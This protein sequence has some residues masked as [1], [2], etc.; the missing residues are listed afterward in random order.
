MTVEPESHGFI[1]QFAR[2]L[3]GRSGHVHPL[4]EAS[5]R[6][7]EFREGRSAFKARDLVG[8]LLSHGARAYRASQPHAVTRLKVRGVGGNSAIRLRIADNRS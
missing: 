5:L 7:S 2:G 3:A 6:L 4:R 1:D 8:L